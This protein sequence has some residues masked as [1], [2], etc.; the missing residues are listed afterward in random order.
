MLTAASGGTVAATTPA[1]VSSL[2][3]SSPAVVSS[4]S[5]QPTSSRPVLRVI[6]PNTRSTATSDDVSMHLTIVLARLSG[7]GI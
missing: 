3:T 7:G 6:I 5:S 2:T 1:S 4:P